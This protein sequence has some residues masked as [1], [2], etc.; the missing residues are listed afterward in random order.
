MDMDICD[1]INCHVPC[2]LFRVEISYTYREEIWVLAGCHDVHKLIW[3]GK[4][5]HLRLGKDEISSP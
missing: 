2:R 3:F 5:G 4:V 1:I